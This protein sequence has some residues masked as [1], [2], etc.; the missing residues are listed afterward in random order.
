MKCQRCEANEACISFT[1]V[2]GG[3]SVVLHLCERCYIIFQ[4]QKENSEKTKYIKNQV[5]I[6]KISKEYLQKKYKKSPKQIL[7]VLNKELKECHQNKDYEREK[8]IQKIIEELK[9]DIK[10]LEREE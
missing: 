10:T 9:K 2:V 1:H 5:P 3:K 8:I 7:E 4:S 6:K